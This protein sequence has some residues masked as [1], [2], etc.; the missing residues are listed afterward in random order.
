M[1]LSPK[2]KVTVWGYLLYIKLQWLHA[3]CPPMWTPVQHGSPFPLNSQCAS[4]KSF[5][6][7]QNFNK[8]KQHW[9]VLLCVVE[10]WWVIQSFQG[11]GLAG[12]DTCQ[13][14]LYWK[15]QSGYMTPICVIPLYPHTVTFNQKSEMRVW[16]RQLWWT[17][18]SAN[19]K[20]QN[21]CITHNWTR[22]QFA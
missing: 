22:L 3:S 18:L 13:R 19:S 17:T 1:A 9:T 20:P 6:N 2:L 10:L 21:V 8:Y 14:F 15:F 12:K 11:L 4:S 16:K 7:L 5:V